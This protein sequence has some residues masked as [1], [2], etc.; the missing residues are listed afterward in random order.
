MDIAPCGDSGGH[1]DIGGNDRPRYIHAS[2]FQPVDSVCAGAGDGGAGA[3]AARGV[4]RGDPV[5]IS[6]AGGGAVGPKTGG[7]TGSGIPI[8]PDDEPGDGNSVAGGDGGGG[9]PVD[10]LDECARA[11]RAGTPAAK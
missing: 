3:E 7:G 9:A 10:S 2:A 1:R 11:E 4:G 5:H 8:L 6:D